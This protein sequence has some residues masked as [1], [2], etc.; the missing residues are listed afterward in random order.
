MNGPQIETL[1][2][3]SVLAGIA[4]YLVMGLA[5]YLWTHRESQRPMPQYPRPAVRN[6][7]PI[8]QSERVRSG[9]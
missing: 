9:R 3:A 8:S 4:V 6:I 7:Q 1:I 5:R 2:V